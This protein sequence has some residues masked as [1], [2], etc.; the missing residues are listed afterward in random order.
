MLGRWPSRARRGSRSRTTLRRSVKATYA[1]G[2]PH[3]QPRPVLP[4]PSSSQLPH[5]RRRNARGPGGPRAAARPRSRRLQ[6]SGH[7]APVRP[8][9]D[10]RRA[11]PPLLPDGDGALRTGVRGPVVRRRGCGGVGEFSYY[12]GAYM[13]LQPGDDRDRG[14]L[15][16]VDSRDDAQLPGTDVDQR[17]PRGGCDLRRVVG[18]RRVPSDRG[19][20]R[21]RP[22]GL[23]VDGTDRRAVDDRAVAPGVSPQPGNARTSGGRPRRASST[24][25][26]PSRAIPPTSV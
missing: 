22:A 14:A 8:E 5:G 25:S 9:P 20:V 3:H 2:D 11:S 1:L 19:V 26:G 4:P 12:A 18:G 13:R 24:R 17:V 7:G 23:A 15:P 16:G 6:R 10:A 21:Q